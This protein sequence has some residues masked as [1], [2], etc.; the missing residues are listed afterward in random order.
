[1]HIPWRLRCWRN[2]LTLPSDHP[3][4]GPSLAPHF[5]AGP[6]PRETRIEDSMGAHG[7]AQA[8]IRSCRYVHRS[9]FSTIFTHCIP[10]ITVSLSLNTVGFLRP[11]IALL[12]G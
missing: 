12:M 7:E 2:P 9:C 3:R 10:F 6:S 1:V 5:R 4:A 11:A 8:D